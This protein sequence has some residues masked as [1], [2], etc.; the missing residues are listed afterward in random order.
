MTVVPLESLP[1]GF[2]FHPTDEELVNHYLKRKITGRIRA[3]IEVIPEIDVCKCEPWDLPDKSLIKSDDREWFF[4]APKDRKYPNGQRSNRATEAGYWK[5]TGKDRTIRSKKNPATI[6][7]KKTL[8]FHKG[9]APKGERTQWIMH[10][11]R[12][13][14]PEYES[15]DQ[16]GFVLYRLFN[17]QEEKSPSSN[18]DEVERSGFSPTPSRSSPGDTQHDADAM[19]ETANTSNKES[20]A[21]DLQEDPLSIPDS[22]ENQP[23]GIKRW[24]ADKADCSTAYT[25]KADENFHNI[26]PENCV[27]EARAKGASVDT[28]DLFNAAYLQELQMD[29]CDEMNLSALYENASLLPY[30]STQDVYSVDS[31]AESL[32]EM[33]HS[34]EES[35]N[36]N[37]IMGGGG[38]LTSSGI[39][40]IARQYQQPVDPNFVFQQQGTANRRILL[41]NS[42]QN[43]LY[44]KADS[45]TSCTKQDYEEHETIS[46]P[47]KDSSV[48]ETSTA[49]KDIPTTG[50]TIRARQPRHSLNS[51]NVVTQQGTAVRRLR[52]QCKLQAG[53]SFYTDNE[54]SR[55]K[56]DGH[57]NKV[58]ETEVM[59][60]VD[61]NTPNTSAVP[62]VDLVDKLAEL[63]VHDAD[64]TPQP[65]KTYHEAKPNMRLRAK[66]TGEH[67]NEV[68]GPISPK[69][70]PGSIVYVTCLVLS[71][72]LL[73]LCV[74]IW[75]PLHS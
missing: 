14:E 57:Q 51:N 40:I 22:V 17:K 9:R 54:S 63:S 53:P 66:R 1:L 25:V 39:R 30:T 16:G 68:Q 58:A 29:A 24:L 55:T 71:V 5:A 75:K 32:Q 72:F 35:S 28:S 38:N 34:V 23:A 69:R 19:E 4:F 70:A 2:R 11:Y 67:E 12:T 18:A 46:K 59:E 62:G 42:I 10:E 61:E 64:D 45:E 41:Q 36:P 48:E 8:V 31:T 74:G 37:N 56:E 27:G 33:Y 60:H 26:N 43:P 47:V 52:L 49:E 15:G 7:M 20:P 65:L 21:S 3:E 13:T 50:I 6:G 44:P 73:L